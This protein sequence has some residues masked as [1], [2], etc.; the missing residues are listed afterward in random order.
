MTVSVVCVDSLSA[1]SASDQAPLANESIGDELSH[2]E[3]I[4]EVSVTGSPT[5]SVAKGAPQMDTIVVTASRSLTPLLQVPQSVTVIDAEAFQEPNLGLGLDE[6][7]NRVPGL[8]FQ[9]RYNFAQNIRISTRGFGARAPFG[10]RGIQLLSDG[11]PE[12]LPDGQA[13]VDA[14]D[15]QSLVGAEVMRG[16]SS[17]LYGNASGGVIA[18]RTEDGEGIT[19]TAHTRLGLGSDGFSQFGLQAG[20]QWDSIHGWVSVSDLDYQGQRDHSGTSKR[21]L[22]ANGTLSLAPSHR[23]KMAATVLDQPFGKDPGALTRDQVRID[24]WQASAQSESLNAGQMVRQERLGLRHEMELAN[25]S[26]L[27]SYV[28]RTSRDF[29]QQLPSSFFPSLIAFQRAFYGAGSSLRVSEFNDWRLTAGLDWAKQD[30]D[31]QRYRVDP[32]GTVLAQTQNERQLAESSALFVQ[33]HRQWNDWSFQLGLRHDRLDLTIDEFTQPAATPTAR[34]FKEWVWMAGTTYAFNPRLSGFLNWSEGFES[35]T[36]TEI[37]DLTGGGGFSRALSPAYASNHE[38]GLRAFWT[39]GQLEAGVFWIDTR[40]EI[41]V[42]DSFDGVDIF[43][44]A[45]Q[46]QRLGFELGLEHAW[47]ESLHGSLAY[48]YADYQFET[49]AVEGVRFDGNALPG[50]PKHSIFSQAKFLLNDSWSLFVDG[51]WVGSMYADNA[52]TQR[53]SSYGLINA[54][55]ELDQKLNNGGRLTWSLGINNV[56][57]QAYFSNVRVNANRGAYFEPGPSRAWFVRLSW[58]P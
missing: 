3:P 29:E 26:V 57:N 24:R 28:F 36:F 53:V 17:V 45:G 22:N 20:G 50:L 43:A 31:R 19:P 2:N 25:Q 46:T 12:T 13:Q 7:L 37:K 48:T 55:A 27:S 16:P 6:W 23:L 41:V 33:A 54:R 56:F 5:A 52:N 1:R 38:A 35:P 8:F 11:F 51:L 49:F 21:L 18:L 9:N 39:D 30:D 32:A 34:R 14:V 44:N 40:D 4:G 47:S 42:I 58:Q 10:V 15:L